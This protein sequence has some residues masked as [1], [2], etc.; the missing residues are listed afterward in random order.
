MLVDRRH[1]TLVEVKRALERDEQW[2]A[3]AKAANATKRA[4]YQTELAFCNPP[5][6]RGKA[7]YM[8]V[9][10]LVAWGKKMLQ[11]LDSPPLENDSLNL[12]RL[13]DKLGWIKQYREAIDGWQSVMNVIETVETTVRR[14]G[15]HALTRSKIE[16]TLDATPEG[17]LAD[18]LRV[19][20]LEF[21]DQNAGL[22]DEGDSLPGSSEVLESI[23]GKY[24]NLQGESGQFGVTGM[25]LSIGALIGRVTIATI[26]TALE[27]TSAVDVKAWEK[28]H[29]GSTVGAQ[30]VA[31]FGPPKNRTER[32]T[33]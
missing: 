20:L 4:V 18:R 1:A 2:L 26:R 22:T 9:D 21:V 15:Y 23:F 19:E 24:K 13:Q 33:G 28:K 16:S 29:L 31:A 17:S 14:E 12:S 30:R 8:S 10:I 25:V 6:Q 11:L 5:A 7:R 3:F 32:G 27:S